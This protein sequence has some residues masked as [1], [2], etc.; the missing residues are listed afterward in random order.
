MTN[1][2]KNSAT[3]KDVA[4]KVTTEVKNA[5]TTVPAQAANSNTEKNVDRV[6][7]HTN[8]TLFS[9]TQAEIVDWLNE[10]SP[11][12][13]VIQPADHPDL[14]SSVD[15]LKKHQAKLSPVQRIKAAAEKLGKN[16]KAMLIIGASAVAVGLAAKNRRKEEVVVETLDDVEVTVDNPDDNPD[17][18]TDSL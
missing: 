14:V 1:T 15:Y 10:H 17:D 16:R 7:D 5:E 13:Y 6:V 11:M 12:L 8:K 4:A 2:N 3:P 18:T 9:G